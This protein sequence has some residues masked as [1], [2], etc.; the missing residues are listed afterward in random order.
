MSFTTKGLVA[1]REDGKVTIKE[2]GSVRKFKKEITAISF[3]AK[4]AI[5]RGQNVIY[6][7]ERCVFQL[8]PKGLALKEVYP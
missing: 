1:V 8:T 3:S 5:R 6:V 7:T 4:N 2:E